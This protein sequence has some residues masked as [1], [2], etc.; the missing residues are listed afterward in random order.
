MVVTNIAGVVTSSA[1]F[2][3]LGFADDFDSYATPVVVTNPATTNGYKI[4]YSAASGGADFKAIFGFDYSTVT[5]PTIIPPAPN[6]SGTTKGLY[7]T[8]NKFDANA[9]AAAVNFYPI[10]TVFTNNFSLKFDLWINWTNLATSTEHALFGIDHSG[11]V[12]NR[13]GQATSDGIFFAMDGDGG[14]SATSGTIRDYSVFLGEG[15]G[16]APLLLANSTVFGPT[17]PLGANFDNSDPGFVSLFPS[18]AIP[19]FGNTPA[20]SSG[21]RWVSVEVRQENNL[22]TWLLDHVAVVQFTNEFYSGGTI[23]IGYNDAFNSIGDPNNFAVSL[24]VMCASGRNRSTP[25]VQILPPTIAGPGFDFC[26]WHRRV[27]KLYRAMD[28]RTWVTGPWVTYTNFLGDGATDSVA[29]PLPA[30]SAAAYFR[31][32]RP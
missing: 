27:R 6:S 19:G 15:A 21:M 17:P 32:T 28:Q 18:L 24:T 12:T 13:I 11:N 16:L 23:A 22:V 3:T 20:G 2:L 25:P 5:S 1:A 31:V 30:S 7:V 9:A 14:V 8:V 4:F 26:F 10:G 29:V